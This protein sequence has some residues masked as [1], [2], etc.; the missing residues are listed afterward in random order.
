MVLVE[1]AGFLEDGTLFDSSYTRPD[2]FKFPLAQGAVIKGWDEGVASMKVG[3]KRQ[4]YIPFDLAYGEAGRPPTI[5][6]KATLIFEVELVSIR[7]K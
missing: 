3:G 5:P 4:L 1:Y 7:G 2:S 6:A